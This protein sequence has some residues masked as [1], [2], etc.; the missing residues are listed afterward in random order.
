VV[1]RLPDGEACMIRQGYLPWLRGGERVAAYEHHRG[2]FAEHSTPERYLASNLAVLVEALRH[3]PG[4]LRGVDPTA[5]VH[6][7]AILVEPLRIGPGAVV[8]ANATIANA[9]VGAGA[10]VAAGVTVERAVV[11]PGAHV[12]ADARDAIVDR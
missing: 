4:R 6:P 9:V 8:G 2:Y 11:W 10:R 3:P 1:S 5:R 7:D 12:A